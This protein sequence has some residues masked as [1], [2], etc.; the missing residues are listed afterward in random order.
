MHFISCG[1]EGFWFNVVPIY[2]GLHSDK[3][4]SGPTGNALGS[5]TKLHC[6]VPAGLFIDFQKFDGM[7]I[8]SVTRHCLAD[9]SPSKETLLR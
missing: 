9:E 4:Q 5:K 8:A 6:R 7:V 2:F 1:L 3:M